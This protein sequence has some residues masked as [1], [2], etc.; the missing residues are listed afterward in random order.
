MNDSNSAEA[1][2]RVWIECWNEGTPKRPKTKR[3]RLSVR[4]RV[5]D[6]AR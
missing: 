3:S 4:R 2:A 6:G 5:N 1:L